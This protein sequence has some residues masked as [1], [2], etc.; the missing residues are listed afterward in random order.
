[1]ITV[2]LLSRE[3]L[4][5]R[6]RFV[7]KLA[8]GSCTAAYGNNLGCQKDAPHACTTCQMK[9]FLEEESAK[10]NKSEQDKEMDDLV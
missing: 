8:S 9:W 2:E 3:Q 4:I 1:M 7:E 6:A 5:A 10:A